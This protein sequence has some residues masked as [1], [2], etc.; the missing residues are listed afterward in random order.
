MD[1]EH[2]KEIQSDDKIKK[3]MAKW[4]VYDFFR[5]YTNLEDLHDRISDDE[6]KTLMKQAVNNI[7]LYLSILFQPSAEANN[8]IELFTDK[9]QLA[10]QDWNKWDD[11]EM[12]E[13][14]VREGAQLFRRLQKR[15]QQS[16]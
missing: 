6:M 8:L 1:P 14:R 12:P 10:M 11:P 13:E 16:Q 9:E 3:N 2:L 15:H 4:L 5:N 7:Y